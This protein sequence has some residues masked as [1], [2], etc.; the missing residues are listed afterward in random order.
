MKVKKVLTMNAEYVY[1]SYS[2]LEI[3]D[4]TGDE[5]VVGMTKELWFEL[6]E[7]VI[8]KC[9]RYREEDKQKLLEEKENAD[10]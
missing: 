10:G 6:E 7:K 1:C 2:G 4:A 3:N 5:A 8:A 9:N